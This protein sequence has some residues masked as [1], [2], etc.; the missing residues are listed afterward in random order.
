MGKSNLYSSTAGSLLGA[1]AKSTQHPLLI[2]HVPCNPCAKSL[3]LHCNGCQVDTVTYSPRD[4]LFP[5]GNLHV[6]LLAWRASFGGEILW[7]W[8]LGSWDMSASHVPLRGWVAW[9]ICWTSIFK[10]KVM[11][12]WWGLC[13]LVSFS[14][15]RKWYCASLLTIF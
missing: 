9:E 7:A 3:A 6:P 2:P 12:G 11:K 5:L 10:S 4:N 13:S 1:Q 8:F 14:H 15:R